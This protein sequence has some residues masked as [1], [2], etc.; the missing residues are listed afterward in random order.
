MST[1]KLQTLYNPGWIVTREPHNFGQRL[2]IAVNTETKRFGVI[3][4]DRSLG[5]VSLTEPE[6]RLVN[7]FIFNQ[8]GESRE[9]TATPEV[10][11]LFATGDN[12]YPFED[13]RLSHSFH[14]GD[15]VLNVT[16][17]E[18][19]TFDQ[20]WDI[21]GLTI[22]PNYQLLDRSFEIRKASKNDILSFLTSVDIFADWDK[23]ETPAEIAKRRRPAYHF[24]DIEVDGSL[25]KFFSNDYDKAKE[26]G[27]LI[28][29]PTGDY[30]YKRSPTSLPYF[31]AFDLITGRVKTG[32]ADDFQSYSEFVK[33][34]KILGNEITRI[35]VGTITNLDDSESY[36]YNKF[37]AA[38]SNLNF[39][40]PPNGI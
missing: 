31:N 8:A 32:I 35:S 38:Y 21:K 27:Y 16:T 5:F 26:G 22:D 3:D 36:L 23:L 4:P 12:L 11:S 18:R 1:I 13:R 39:Y 20:Y 37:I 25:W 24:A 28:K 29:T 14:R 7:D 17:G 19:F 30:F 6:I 40:Q 34:V 10:E 15:A 2:T 9:A 33:D